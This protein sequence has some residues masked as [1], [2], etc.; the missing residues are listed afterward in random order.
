MLPLGEGEERKAFGN[1]NHERATEA[2]HLQEI[3]YV[4]LELGYAGP[5]SNNSV[6]DGNT[7]FP[8]DQTAWKRPL[9]GS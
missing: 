1:V 6:N 5:P 9:I 8:S 2:V 3:V 4:A 7:G